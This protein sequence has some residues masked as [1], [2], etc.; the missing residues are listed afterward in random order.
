[1]A[2][3]RLADRLAR[4]PSRYWRMTLYMRLLWLLILDRDLIEERLEEARSDQGQ[5]TRRIQGAVAR[6]AQDYARKTLGLDW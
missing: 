4:D 1:M 2:T 6:N 5:K 3:K